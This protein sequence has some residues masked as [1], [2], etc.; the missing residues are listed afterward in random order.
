MVVVVD[1]FQ[2]TL[3]GITSPNSLTDP[4]TTTDHC[5]QSEI[6]EIGTRIE[7]YDV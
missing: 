4:P 5:N 2:D 7:C 1:C 3:T 6:I